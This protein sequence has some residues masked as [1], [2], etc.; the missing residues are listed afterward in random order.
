MTG[1]RAHSVASTTTIVPVLGMG[2]VTKIG[3][4]LQFFEFSD[5]VGG[6]GRGRLLLCLVLLQL[7]HTVL[8]KKNG[9]FGFCYRR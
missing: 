2:G 8:D 1:E 4:A 7:Q 9:H 3:L 6:V 5:G